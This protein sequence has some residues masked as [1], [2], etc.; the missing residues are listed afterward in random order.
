MSFKKEKEIREENLKKKSAATSND[1]PKAVI[2]PVSLAVYPSSIS[3][4]QMRKNKAGAEISK[5][6]SP[7]KEKRK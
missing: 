4:E 6:L 2:R 3:V 5:N 1:A 7:G